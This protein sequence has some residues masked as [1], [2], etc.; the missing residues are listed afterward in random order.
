MIVTDANMPIV[1]SAL[2][3]LVIFLFLIGIMQFFRVRAEK[4]ELV[5]KV[6]RYT[7][8][9]EAQGKESPSI[10]AGGKVKDK[11]LEFFNRLGTKVFPQKASDFGQAKVR[12]LRG[13]LRGRNVSAVFWGAKFFL[14]VLFPLC[15]FSTS[16]AILGLLNPQVTLAGCLM[17]ALL[18][19]YLPDIW[20]SLRTS[21]RKRSIFEGF[22]DALD[23]F[24]VC[25]EAG[26]GLD[27]AI[28]RVAE[29]LELS[30]TVLSDELKYM[31]LEMR[32][33]KSRHDAL[34]NLA[35]RADMED[36]TSLV[37]MLIQSDKFGTSMAQ[38]LRVYSDS[39]R[40]KR[41]QRAEEIAAKLP[42]KLVLPLILF[43]FPSL[44]VAILGPAAIRLYEVILSR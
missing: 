39:F 41:Y 44:F 43:I 25:V 23:L 9:T 26:M 2:G 11:I 8:E 34:R 1:V 27:A 37:T 42:V 12:F 36:V 31:N 24:V 3:F 5:E 19:F 20:L 15:F 6:H 40:T 28:N 21:K 4:R 33:G 16:I 38:A 35:L 10:E 13:G 7:G 29:E 22:P 30:N 14:M 18:G 32:A 17:L